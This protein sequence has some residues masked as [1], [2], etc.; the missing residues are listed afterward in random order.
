M[1]KERMQTCKETAETWTASVTRPSAPDFAGRRGKCAT[2]VTVDVGSKHESGRIKEPTEVR[3]NENK[4][5]SNHIMKLCHLNTAAT[6]WLVLAFCLPS[7]AWASSSKT[8]TYNS[9][10]GATDETQQPCHGT[11]RWDAKT[12]T[13]KPPKTI[14]TDHQITPPQLA[15]WPGL[16]GTFDGSAARSGR[17]LEWYELTGRV[18]K[19]YAEK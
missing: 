11:D 18:V 10:C 17:E 7:T 6:L 4:F 3:M 1:I 14:P 19:V 5:W 16:G 12:E 2:S 8:C 9:S 15:E 13:T